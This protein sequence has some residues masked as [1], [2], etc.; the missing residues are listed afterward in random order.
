M[1]LCLRLPAY[2]ALKLEDQITQWFTLEEMVP[3]VSQ[4]ILAIEMRAGDER[5][6]QLLQPLDDPLARAMATAEKA[7]LAQIGGGCQVAVGAQAQYVDHQL[8]LCAMI[9]ATDGRLVRDT[10]TGSLDAAAT[11]GAT[12]A[13]QLLDSGG[14]ELLKA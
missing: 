10:L 9:G 4:G 11:L 12:L 14:R 6:A 5:V 1:R 8:V 3:A 7:V 13:H 2:Y